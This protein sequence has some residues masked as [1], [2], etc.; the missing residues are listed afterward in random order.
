MAER[1]GV[2]PCAEFGVGLPQ[3]CFIEDAQYLDADSRAKVEPRLKAT[4]DALVCMQGTFNRL[5]ALPLVPNGLGLRA[6][7]KHDQGLNPTRPG[8]GV[9]APSQCAGAGE[10]VVFTVPQ[11]I[12][13]I[14][15]QNKTVVYDILFRATAETLPAMRQGSDGTHRVFPAWNTSAR[16]ARS[17]PMS[18]HR[19]PQHVCFA[20]CAANRWWANAAFSHEA[21][22]RHRL[23]RFGTDR[24]TRS[25]LAQSCVTVEAPPS[26][27]L[28][29][30]CPPPPAPRIRAGG[31]QSP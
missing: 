25:E 8:G 20:S 29:D 18:P 2:D 31:I 14:A 5:V 10:H 16:P 23:T 6:V 19:R 13:A 26:T 1:C 24:L 22:H 7:G 9:A 12:A 11:Q 28:P 30:H 27:R 21:V 3:P 15:Y 17:R 4:R